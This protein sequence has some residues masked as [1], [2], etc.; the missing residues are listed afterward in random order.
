M[1]NGA[2]KWPSGK[3]LEVLRLLQTTVK[4]MYGLEIVEKSDGAV[5]RAS[6]YIVL[7]RL[8]EKGFVTVARPKS[9]DHPGLPR[10][11][12]RINGEGARAVAAAEMMGMTGAR[13]R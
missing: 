2:V 4:G 1:G 9:A 12:Y 11:V 7:G 13:A 3:E 6:V 10:P 8:E 5:G